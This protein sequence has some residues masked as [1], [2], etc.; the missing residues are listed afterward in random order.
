M[1]D[2]YNSFIWNE[3]FGINGQQNQNSVV[4]NLIDALWD[5][6]PDIQ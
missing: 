1:S 4:D 5:E 2:T 6:G 3:I